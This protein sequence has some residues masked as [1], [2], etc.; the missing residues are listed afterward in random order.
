MC[1]IFL[2]LE[3][4]EMHFSVGTPCAAQ[5][6]PFAYH[7]A[8]HAMVISEECPLQFSACVTL[9]LNRRHPDCRAKKKRFFFSFLWYFS[10]I[11]PRPYINSL[12]DVFDTE[13][14]IE[15]R[16]INY[17]TLNFTKKKKIINVRSNNLE[18]QLTR[19][20]FVTSTH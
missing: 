17:I 13:K 7:F 1:S 8:V 9:P 20:I 3:M 6:L 4:H 10:R 16:E 15:T 5:V 11:F 14:I 18:S 2:L 12:P 19:E